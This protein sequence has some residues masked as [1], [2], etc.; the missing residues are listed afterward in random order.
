MP[1]LQVTYKPISEAKRM[2]LIFKPTE[3]LQSEIFT[4]EFTFRNI[5]EEFQGGSC[6]FLLRYPDDIFSYIGNIKIPSIGMGESTTRLWTNLIIYSHGNIGLVFDNQKYRTIE[7]DTIE[8][9]YLSDEYGN[10]LY[11]NNWLFFL[12]SSKEEMYQ[13]YSVIVAVYVAIIS[14]ILSTIGI[15]I[16]LFFP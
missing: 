2:F 5:G 12:V 10:R 8:E 15:F 11:R 14:I 3:V 9:N 1:E 6:D 4:I 7:G 13:K 16:S